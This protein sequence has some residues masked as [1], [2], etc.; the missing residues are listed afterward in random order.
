MTSQDIL[1]NGLVVFEAHSS[2][3]VSQLLNEHIDPEDTLYGGC[4]WDILTIERE[5]VKQHLRDN[6]IYGEYEAASVEQEVTEYEGEELDPAGG[7]G[8]SSHI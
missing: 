8:L 2:E 1:E 3:H 7:Y 6:L 5:E 4:D